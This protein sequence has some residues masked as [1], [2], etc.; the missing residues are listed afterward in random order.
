LFSIF[1]F[2]YNINISIKRKIGIFLSSFI[3]G[4][5]F[6]LTIWYQNSFSLEWLSSARPVHQGYT[7]LLAR[8]TYKTIMAVGPIFLIFLL[9][10]IVNKRKYLRK[11]DNF[12][13][14]ISIILINLLIF[15]Y[16]PAEL[17][18]LQPML[19]SLYYLINKFFNKKII[20]IF[21]FLNLFTWFIDFNFLEVKYK[22]N[23]HCDNIEAISARIDFKFNDGKLNQFYESRNKIVDCWIKDKKRGDI[24]KNGGA[25][26]NYK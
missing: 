7:G 10:S 24:I 1:L 18:Y 22:S 4:G 21:V 17:S 11:F 20:Y 25:L 5:L 6:Y 2:H 26:K 16:I 13:L 9:W 14:I 19:I 12:N 3:I 8:F 15:I 23:N